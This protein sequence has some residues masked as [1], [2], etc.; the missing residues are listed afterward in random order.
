MNVRS[1]VRRRGAAA[2]RKL[3]GAAAKA[4]SG[5]G[6]QICGAPRSPYESLSFEAKPNLVRSFST[7]TGCGF[8]SIEE[9]TQDR[10]RTKTSM[11]QLPNADRIGTE[12]TPGR[13]FLMARMAIDILQRTG[14][15][16]LVYGIGRSLDNLHIANMH[17]VTNVAIG[18]IMKLRDDAE[19]HDANQ[20]ATKTFPVV[21]ASEVIEHFRNPHEDFAKLF[22]FVSKD[23]IL[24]CGTNV[25]G[26]GDL[27]K[28]RYPFYPDHTSYYTPEALLE[29]A[30]THGFYL[31][32]RTPK[33]A[34]ERGRKRY[35]IF[36]KSPQVLQNVALHFGRVAVAPSE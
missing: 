25:Y 19:F 34:G 3:K 15:E 2:K 23:G 35:V 33:M 7:C 24:V 18:D 26:G 13:E 1:E 17:R 21:I 5:E 6:C 9:L 31:D 28:D 11:D 30:K 4:Q 12:D 8:V 14:V 29:V 36:T 27:T 20:P 10:Y 16:V 22:Q 32:F